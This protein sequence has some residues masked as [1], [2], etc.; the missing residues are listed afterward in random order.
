MA[1]RVEP[2]QS[3][4]GKRKAAGL[5]AGTTKATAKQPSRA[6]VKNPTLQVRA[7]GHPQRQPQSQKP[8]SVAENAILCAIQTG[9]EKRPAWRPALRREAVAN[10]AGDF[11]GEGF[12]TRVVARAQQAAPLRF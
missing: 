6:Q 11:C 9:S 4:K 8:Q 2:P 12:A 7:W 10:L 1:K 3:Q 5:K